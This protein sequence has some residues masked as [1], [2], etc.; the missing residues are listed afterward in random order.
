M[1][2]LNIPQKSQK[3]F[4]PIA[5][6]DHYYSDDALTTIR[7]TITKRHGECLL[8]IC[9]YLR[10]L[11]YQI[12][13]NSS[14]IIE[15]R[16]L[17]EVHEFMKRL[18]RCGFYR[19]GIR[20]MSMMSFVYRP[21]YLHIQDRICKLIRD[22]PLLLEFLAEHSV[23]TLA[24]FDNPNNPDN[25]D[26]Q[27]RYFVSE[28]TLGIYLTEILGYENEYYGVFDRGLI[29][30]LYEN[31]QQNLLSIINKNKLDRKFHSLSGIMTPKR[32]L[33][34]RTDMS[35]GMPGS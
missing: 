26:T 33:Q 35:I 1:N 18:R 4:V 17:M 8:V 19:Y 15:K 25:R 31:Y 22:E 28:T 34:S 23:F 13:G 12:R 32:F 7:D 2:E 11:A 10:H 9:D 16:I 20:S 21:A 30:L 27:I 6:G 24:K 3:A 5:L 29:V 14:G